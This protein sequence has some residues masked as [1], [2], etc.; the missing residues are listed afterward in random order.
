MLHVK[1]KDEYACFP[2]LQAVRSFQSKICCSPV[3]WDPR[4]Q[5][6]LWWE[7]RLLGKEVVFF[8][9]GA[10]QRGNVCN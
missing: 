3:V 4:D 1:R 10:F 5:T 7:R 8:S 6:N 2:S 9:N